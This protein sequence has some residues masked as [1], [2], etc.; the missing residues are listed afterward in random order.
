MDR[1]DLI[2]RNVQE[3]VTE[4]ELE[5]LLNKK[6]APRAYV[7]YEP[8]GKIHMGHVLTV[9]KLIDLQKAGFEITVLLADVH[10]YLNRKGTLEEVRKIADYNKRCFIAL[11]LD[12]EKTNFVYGS[13]YQLGAEYMLNVL[14]LSRSVT[15]NRARRSMDEVGRAMDDPTVSQ[16]VYPLMQAIDIALLGVDIAVGGI[17]Q[18]KIHM[19]ARENLKNLGFETPICIHTPILLGLD[20]TKMASSKENF[21]SVDDTEE[22]IY[23]KLKKA[24]CKIGDTEENPILALFRYHIFPRYETV[25]IERPEKFG[26]NITY[27]SYEEMENAFAAESV[28]PMD[29]KNSAAK[30]INEI[31]D[32][33]RKVLL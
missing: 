17:D 25:V 15:L 1:L 24:Y 20:G 12:K 3:I 21:I 5:E 9:N 19:L 6:K 31:L 23:K 33:V 22:E 11:G 27:V 32:P 8:S 30:Y 26:G 28:H 16:M 13:D 2:K 4:G 10:A 29:L 14:K 18:R 7:G